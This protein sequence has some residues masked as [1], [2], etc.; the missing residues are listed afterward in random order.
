M[1]AS[2]IVKGN[3]KDVNHIDIRRSKMSIEFRERRIYGSMPSAQVHQFRG[4]SV[5]G[6]Y[7]YLVFISCRR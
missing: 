4:Q 2:C 3:R 5:H 7:W 6:I 1:I